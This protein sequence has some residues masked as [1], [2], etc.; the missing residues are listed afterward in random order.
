M[1]HKKHDKLS[2]S[3][4]DVRVKESVWVIDLCLR[5]MK[6]GDKWLL[7]D[8]RAVVAVSV[9]SIKQ[10]LKVPRIEGSGELSLEQ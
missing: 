5:F 9:E 3:P 2:V 7:L 6:C 10:R 8:D 1:I 4:Y